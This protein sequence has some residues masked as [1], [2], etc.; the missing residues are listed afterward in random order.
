MSEEVRVAVLES[1]MDRLESDHRGGEQ[2]LAALED[3]LDLLRMHFEV[4]Q[5][6]VTIYAAMGA[7]AGGPLF[8]IAADVIRSYL[9]I[10]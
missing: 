2:R 6:R 1:R 9:N 4:L 7:V 8:S 3:K 5:A 10:R